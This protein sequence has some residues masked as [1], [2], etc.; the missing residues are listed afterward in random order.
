MPFIHLINH[1]IT[2]PT[3]NRQKSPRISY[4][5]DRSNWQLNDYIKG[6]SSMNQNLETRIAERT[7]KGKIS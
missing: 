4:N 3:D 7:R 5:V 1:G 2:K 6:V